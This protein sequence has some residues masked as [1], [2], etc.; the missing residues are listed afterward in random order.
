MKKDEDTEGAVA[1]ITSSRAE[2]STIISSTATQQNDT[3]SNS[4]NSS[5]TCSTGARQ[6]FGNWTVQVSEAIN[7]NLILVRYGTITSIVLLSA[8][9]F[10]KTP[11][12]FRYK[13]VNDIPCVGAELPLLGHWQHY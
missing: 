5:S 11:L 9:G 6:L 10:Y 3:V 8:Y 1:K 4:R 12:F 7:D 13:S 2:S